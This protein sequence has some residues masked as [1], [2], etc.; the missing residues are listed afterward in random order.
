MCPV[1][2]STQRCSVKYQLRVRYSLT[3]IGTLRCPLYVSAVTLSAPS[4]HVW[5]AGRIS[6]TLSVSQ[7]RRPKK[8]RQLHSRRQLTCRSLTRATRGPSHTFAVWY[9]TCRSHPPHVRAAEK[10]SAQGNSSVKS[11]VACWNHVANWPARLLVLCLTTH[12]GGTKPHGGTKPYRGDMGQGEGD[13][14]VGD[15]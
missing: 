9:P 5:N 8:L 13:I 2:H 10:T 15:M 11:R 1:G 4:Q 12:R 14:G 3:Q 6:S 7:T